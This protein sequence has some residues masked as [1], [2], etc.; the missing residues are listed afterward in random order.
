MTTE[1]R[2]RW[3]HVK[4]TDKAV[5][6]GP[7]PLL[8]A[9]DVCGGL[10]DNDSSPNQMLW[11]LMRSC[12]GEAALHALMLKSQAGGSIPIITSLK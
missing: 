3:A 10:V 4:H 1:E 8:Q 7:V 11:T 2:Q 5:C 12:L 6:S 9:A